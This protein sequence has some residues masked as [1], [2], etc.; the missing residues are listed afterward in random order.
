MSSKSRENQSILIKAEID[1]LHK[2][3]SGNW[4]TLTQQVMDNYKPIRLNVLQMM[5]ELLVSQCDELYV[6]G[7]RGAGKTTGTSSR[8]RQT[9]LE[10]PRS[11]NG[12]AAE[13]YKQALTRTLPSVIFGLEQQGIFEGLHYFIGRRPPRNWRW[14]K[15]YQPPQEFDK[16]IYF[17][18]G[19]LYT[20]LSQDVTGD[21]R[22]LNLDSLLCDEA[23]LLSKEKLDGDV[24]PAIRGSN[25]RAFKGKSTFLKE[26]YCSTTPLTQSGMWFVK[27]EE[28]AMMY[29]D[30]IKFISSTCEVNKHNLPEDYLEKHSRTAIP[31]IFNAEYKNIRPKFT[32]DSFYPLFDEDKHC[33][34]SFDYS[35]YTKIGQHSDCRGDL[36][37]YKSLPLILGVDWGAA[38]NCLTVNQHIKEEN[39]FRTLKSMYVLGENQKIQDDLFEDFHRYYQHHHTKVIYMHYDLSGNHKTGNTKLTRA[40]QAKKQLEARGWRVKLLS[41]GMNNPQHEAKHML[42]NMILKEDHPYLPRYRMNKSNCRELCLS[43]R[44][45]KT[46]TGRNGDIKKDKSSEKKTT[47]PRQEATDLSDANDAPI[48]QLFAHLMRHVGTSLPNMSINNH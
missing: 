14:P 42:W 17:W 41:T 35:F 23:A 10:M 21:G 25:L 46:T 38:I 24:K 3:G 6:E 5:M 22:S 29:P 16:T 27:M 15:P 12:I 44:H 18:N 11:H 20:I 48:F 13:T 40:K 2:T 37:L 45:A 39:E 32:K 31:W 47:I 4:Q 1:R 34:N 9:V 26:L 43:M 33:Y 30:K 7:G 28:S 36:D 8:M 19:S